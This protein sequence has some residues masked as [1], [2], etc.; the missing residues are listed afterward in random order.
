MPEEKML[1]VSFVTIDVLAIHAQATRRAHKNAH[2]SSTKVA[3][4]QSV[5]LYADLLAFVKVELQFSTQSIK[6]KKVKNVTNTC[7][8]SCDEGS[9]G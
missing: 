8:A 3:S 2:S 1:E 6:R 9:V 5:K 7:D 4:D